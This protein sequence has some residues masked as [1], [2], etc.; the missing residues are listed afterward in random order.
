MLR[1][2]CLAALISMRVSWVPVASF[3][4]AERWYCGSCGLNGLVWMKTVIQHV[5]DFCLLSFSAAR[6]QNPAKA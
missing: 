3:N 2:T 4:A 1:T 5:T 6:L